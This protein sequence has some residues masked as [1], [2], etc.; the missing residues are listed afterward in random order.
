MAKKNEATENNQNKVNTNE[1]KKVITMLNPNA[2]AEPKEAE[3]HPDMVKYWE[4]EGWKV[5]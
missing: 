2:D 4:Q 5:K 1:P 3:V